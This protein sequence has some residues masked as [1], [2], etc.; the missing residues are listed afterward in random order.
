MISSTSYVKGNVPWIK[1][2]TVG[3]RS[4]SV[5]QKISDGNIEYWR[6]QTEKFLIADPICAGCFTPL[7]NFSRLMLCDGCRVYYNTLAF[8]L[9]NPGYTTRY[10]RER[11]K[12]AKE[13]RIKDDLFPLT[14]M[15]ERREKEALTAFQ[16]DERE[17]KREIEREERR[18]KSA[19]CY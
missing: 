2:R 3:A 4:K 11:R 12:K 16:K 18:R 14:G 5:K 17:E 13:K 19:F 8:K 10:S 7:T 1:G 15:K 6:K 9:R